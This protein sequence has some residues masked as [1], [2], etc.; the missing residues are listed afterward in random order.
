MNILVV[1]VGGIILG[2]IAT[3]VMRIR[4]RHGLI[5]NVA[6][7]VAGGLFEGIVIIPLVGGVPITMAAFSSQSV[8]ISLV[9][10]VILLAMVNLFRSRA[11]Q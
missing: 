2:W 7:G 11:S 10:A 9:G 4:S 3:F 5:L 8:L 1:L 6:V